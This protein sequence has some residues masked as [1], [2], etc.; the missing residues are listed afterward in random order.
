MFFGTLKT[1]LIDTSYRYPVYL[2][3]IHDFFHTAVSGVILIT[4]L[5]LSTITILTYESLYN[6]N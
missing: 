6:T 3:F 1:Q 5:V 2:S 4:P